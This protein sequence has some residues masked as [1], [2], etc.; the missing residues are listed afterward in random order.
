MTKVLIVYYSLYGHIHRMAEAVVMGCV[1]SR[2]AKQY[3][4]GCLKRSH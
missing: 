2:A 3:S 1:R 4:G